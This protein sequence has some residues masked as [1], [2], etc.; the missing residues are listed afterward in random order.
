M[1]L[2]R[3]HN[4]HKFK[5]FFFHILT[6]KPKI[7]LSVLKRTISFNEMVLLSTDNILVQL[8]IALV[9]LASRPSQLVMVIVRWFSG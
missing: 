6:S 7:L 5:V 4:M 1:V 3:N 9:F 2:L 8:V